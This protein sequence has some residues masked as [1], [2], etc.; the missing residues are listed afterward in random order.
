MANLRQ[1]LVNFI[2]HFTK[3][4][5]LFFLLYSAFRIPPGPISFCYPELKNILECETLLYT[6]CYDWDYSN[7]YLR[8]FE[9]Y[10]INTNIQYIMPY[11]QQVNLLSLQSFEFSDYNQLYDEHQSTVNSIDATIEEVNSFYNL[12]SK[13]I[14]TWQNKTE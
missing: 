14:Y 12:G 1:F 9:N 6:R 10:T 2:I 5:R 11:F 4:P 13:T 8:G 7:I 3:L